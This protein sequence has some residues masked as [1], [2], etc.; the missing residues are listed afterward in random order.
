MRIYTGNPEISEKLRDLISSCDD[1]GLDPK[2]ISIVGIYNH[3]RLCSGKYEFVGMI[4]T[5]PDRIY[6]NDPTKP[7]RPSA[8]SKTTKLGNFISKSSGSTSAIRGISTWASEKPMSKE[9]MLEKKLEEAKKMMEKARRELI[10]MRFKEKHKEEL[11]K[12]DSEYDEK[13]SKLTSDFEIVENKFNEDQ[14]IFNATLSKLKD[15]KSE[16]IDALWNNFS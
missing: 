1:A 4:T 5:W 3:I 12:I 16:A 11:K 8:R 14:K 10:E 7:V 6:Y 9:E 13:I 15:Q 2:N